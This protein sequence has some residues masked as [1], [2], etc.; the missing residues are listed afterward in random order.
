MRKRR[1]IEIIELKINSKGNIITQEF[2][3][4]KNTT[5]MFKVKEGSEYIEFPSDKYNIEIEKPKNCRY[6]EKDELTSR[7]RELYQLAF[8]DKKIIMNNEYEG[9]IQCFRL[10]DMVKYGKTK[11]FFINKETNEMSYIVINVKNQILMPLLIIFMSGS[12]GVSAITVIKIIKDRKDET[13]IV[14]ETSTPAGVIDTGTEEESETKSNG[15]IYFPSNMTSISVNKENPY[16]NFKNNPANKVFFH[17][18]IYDNA[19]GRTIDIGQIPPTKD[20]VLKF[21]ITKYFS[22]GTHH[23]RIDIKTFKDSAETNEKHPMSYNCTINV[24]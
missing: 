9:N 14:T 11:I 13:K 23:V 17:Y 3:V 10:F 24:N 5:V 12:L 18:Y 6:E 22:T 19:T 16:F 2:T 8:L 1:N 21:D 15:Y 4:K 7:E 20:A